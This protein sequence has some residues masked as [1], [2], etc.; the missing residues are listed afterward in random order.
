MSSHLQSFSWDYIAT[1]LLYTTWWSSNDPI[2]IF[3]FVSNFA[4]SLEILVDSYYEAETSLKKLLETSGNKFKNP[5]CKEADE[6]GTLKLNIKGS[7]LK[8]KTGWKVS[9]SWPPTQGGMQIIQKRS[10]F[11][12]RKLTIWFRVDV[13]DGTKFCDGFFLKSFSPV[14]WISMK[15][16]YK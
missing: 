7:K 14:T 16:K 8:F 12:G 9:N 13:D 6:S 3:D 4:L 1:F 2:T 10:C 15:M 5:W 11:K